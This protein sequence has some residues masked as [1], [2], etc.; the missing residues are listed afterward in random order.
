MAALLE[1][2][3]FVLAPP[4]DVWDAS[5]FPRQAGG[6]VPALHPR[7]RGEGITALKGS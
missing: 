3:H 6:G 5:N 4:P 1:F 7:S 2:L